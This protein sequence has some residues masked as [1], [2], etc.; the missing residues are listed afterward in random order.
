[1]KMIL[2]SVYRQITHHRPMRLYLI[3]V[4][5]FSFANGNKCTVTIRDEKKL[6]IS[7]SNVTTEEYLSE[8]FTNVGEMA[9]VIPIGRLF[10]VNIEIVDSY[11]PTVDDWLFHPLA[12]DRFSSI[13]SVRI[14]NSSVQ[15]VVVKHLSRFSSI[16][17]LGL[18]GNNI[19]DFEFLDE[20]RQLEHLNMDNSKFIKESSFFSYLAGRVKPLQFI[21]LSNCALE[22]FFVTN[23][24]IKRYDLSF[25]PNLTAIFLQHRRG[26]VVPLIKLSFNNNDKLKIIPRNI[27][28]IGTGCIALDLSN[29]HGIFNLSLLSLHHV[30]VMKELI[31]KNCRISSIDPIN[32][33]IRAFIGPP[34]E[35]LIQRFDLSHTGLV[36]ISSSM[37][38]STT[39]FE[40]DLSHN[41][42]TSLNDSIFNNSTIF[43]LNL[44]SSNISHI[45]SKVFSDLNYIESLDLSRNRISS[46]LGIFENSITINSIDLSYNPIEVLHD[47]DFRKCK[48]L[49]SINLSNVFVKIFSGN[50]FA[51]ISSLK[52]LTLSVDS[53]I[54]S[55]S[56]KTSHISELSIVNSTLVKLN[57]EQFKGFYKL[58]RLVFKDSIA[59]SIDKLAFQGLFNLKRISML[60]QL[61]PYHV[62]IFQSLF[63]LEILDLSKH[64]IK[65]L[66]LE[67]NGLYSLRKLNL[68]QNAID[69]VDVNSFKTMRNLEL[70][71]LDHNR[72]SILSIG[73]FRDL[74]KLTHLYLNN[75][76]LQQLSPGMFTG[77]Q[78]LILLDLSRNDL[79]RI[80]PHLVIGIS[81]PRLKFLHLQGNQLGNE[82]AKGDDSARK[83][84]FSVIADHHSLEFIDIN[85]NGWQCITL[86][87]VLSSL[88]KK[89]ISYKPGNV[90]YLAHNINGVSCT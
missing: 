1:M 14:F 11:L 38:S 84:E 75:N 51:R 41:N 70:L 86:I 71:S 89:N 34:G 35:F 7:C 67:L 66:G 36:H 5:F 56:I 39:F 69:S 13:D 44:A 49:H 31:L 77:L 19:S 25:N 48:D 54:N 8:I 61:G 12:A 63:S 57:G 80:K 74:I 81:L 55:E 85:E 2:N 45:S 6:L 50:P 23:S 72:I 21:N 20:I 28:L 4:L 3:L 90:D 87:D 26:P 76:Q 78:N 30:C 59:S 17:K 79:L 65:K 73:T 27:P 64:E 42:L 29:S 10:V 60:K 46:L 9:E 18:G 47:E 22:T 40:L 58:R 43:W 53:A 15:N 88:K 33:N 68:S 16:K 52:S 62:S 32:F 37:L 24:A 82:Y 83:S